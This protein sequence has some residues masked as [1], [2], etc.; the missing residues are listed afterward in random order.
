MNNTCLR[1]WYPVMLHQRTNY[2]FWFLI[3][4]LLT[5]VDFENGL[6][7]VRN[8]S[9]RIF[10]ANFDFSHTTKLLLFVNESFPFGPSNHNKEQKAE[11][12]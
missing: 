6:P 2:N 4:K 3:G 8:E 11:K 5:Q 12:K 9:N 10:F 7:S 1:V